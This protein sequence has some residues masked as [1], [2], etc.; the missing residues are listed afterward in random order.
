MKIKTTVRRLGTLLCLVLFVGSAG[1]DNSATDLENVSLVGEWVFVYQSPPSTTADPVSW[2]FHLTVTESTGGSIQ[3][4]GMSSSTCVGALR[5]FKFSGEFLAPD[6]AIPLGD[7]PMFRGKVTS[8]GNRMVGT[9][10]SSPAVFQRYD[11]STP[12]TSASACP[13]FLSQMEAGGAS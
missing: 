10:A 12:L 6:V 11:R 8:D 7:L 13:A 4:T 2:F 9:W 3:G 1:C 5:D